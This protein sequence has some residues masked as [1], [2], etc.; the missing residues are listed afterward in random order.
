MEGQEA[1][2]EQHFSAALKLGFS[3]DSAAEM[4]LKRSVR[5]RGLYPHVFQLDFIF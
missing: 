2:I 4:R 5:T 1:L 3:L